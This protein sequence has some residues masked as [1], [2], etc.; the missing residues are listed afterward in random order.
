MRYR[1][2]GGRTGTLRQVTLGR[3][4]A[5]TPDEARTFAR[6]ILSAVAH[7][8][9]PALTRTEERSGL[10]L[11]N[12]A[13]LFLSDHVEKKLKRSTAA[14][15]RWTLQ[16]YVLPKLGARPLKGLKQADFARLHL[17]LADVPYQ[18]N[19][20]LTVLGSFFAGRGGAG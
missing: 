2:G 16:K 17:D 4:G 9:D 14:F 19:R 12:I 20:T 13:E 8:N 1:L 18:A 5:L 3:H 15:Y 6:K 10:T 7:G 11:A